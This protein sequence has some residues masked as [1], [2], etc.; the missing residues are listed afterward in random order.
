MEAPGE[1]MVDDHWRFQRDT[2]N[3][4]AQ[5]VTPIMAAALLAHEDIR[6]MGEILSGWDFMDAAESPAPTIFQTTYRRFAE[7]VF[8]DE[9]G[10]GLT[11]AMLGNW[12]FWQERLQKMVKGG[13]STWFDIVTTVGTRET[14]DQL[15]H[16][17]ALQEAQE[18][19]QEIGGPPREWLWGKVHKIDFVNPLR[20]SGSGKSLVGGQIHPMGGSGETLHRGWYDVDSP[21]WVTVSATLRMVVDFNAPDKVLAVL[22]GGVTGRTFHPHFNDQVAPFMSGEKRYWWFSDRAIEEHAV[23]T[24]VLSPE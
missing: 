6:V 7:L 22:P 5:G 16:R 17:A 13:A 8:T 19:G 14:R 23:S 10:T 20:R 4:M 9:L 24:L 15:F 2:K 3:L 21:A 1:K 18:L 11:G 12:Y